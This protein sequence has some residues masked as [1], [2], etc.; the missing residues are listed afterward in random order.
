MDVLKKTIDEYLQ[1]SSCKNTVHAIVLLLTRSL[2]IYFYV[3][4]D[5]LTRLLI[6]PKIKS[7]AFRPMLFKSFD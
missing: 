3:S 6:P 4:D 7:T 2:T 1:S 5:F